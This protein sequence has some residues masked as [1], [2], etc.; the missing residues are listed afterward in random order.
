MGPQAGL[1]SAALTA[2][3]V[4]SKQGLKPNLA[5]ETVYYLRQHSAILAQIFVQLSSIAPQDTIPSTPPPPYPRFSPLPSDVRVNLF[6]FMA[7]AFSLLAALLA[8]LI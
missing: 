7:L 6:W 5:D 3:V 8:I 4:D 2:F 1:F